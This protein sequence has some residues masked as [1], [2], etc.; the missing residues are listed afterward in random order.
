MEALFQLSE[1]I[2]LMCSSHVHDEL[3]QSR[4]PQLGFCACCRRDE[5]LMR[6]VGGGGKSPRHHLS[7]PFMELSSGGLGVLAH[8]PITASQPHLVSL[9]EPETQLHY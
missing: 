8:F 2:A 1:V 4:A 3:C 9:W 7:G 6:S 5:K